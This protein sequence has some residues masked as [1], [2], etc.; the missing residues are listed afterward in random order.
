MAG[1]APLY[2]AELEADLKDVWDALRGEFDIA[3]R[4]KKDAF[5]CKGPSAFRAFV[6]CTSTDQQLD[7]DISQ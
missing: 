4:R 2:S 7:L 5:W 6:W 1:G 3:Y